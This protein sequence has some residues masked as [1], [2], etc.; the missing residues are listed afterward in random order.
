[1]FAE[2][3]KRFREA[4][5]FTQAAFAEKMGVPLRSVQNW[6]QGHREPRL[7]VVVTLAEAL[8]V[9]TDSLLGAPTNARK[10]EAGPA[11]GRPRKEK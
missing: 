7:A 8:G 2:N 11:R 1:M 10:K 3:L 4:A 9:P 5:G 6:E